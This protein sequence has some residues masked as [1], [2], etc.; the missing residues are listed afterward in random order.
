M[1][2]SLPSA[3]QHTDEI[4][5]TA[6]AGHDVPLSCDMC[7]K[8]CPD[9]WHYSTAESRHNH[10][11]DECWKT[12]P[13]AVAPRVLV[14]FEKVGTTGPLPVVNGRVKIPTATMMDL[15]RMLKTT[16]DALAATEQAPAA[17][18][19]ELPGPDLWR[20]ASGLRGYTKDPGQGPWYAA[21]TVRALLLPVARQASAAPHL[22]QTRPIWVGVDLSEDELADLKR[23]ISD[24]CRSGR[25]MCIQPMPAPTLEAPAAHVGD[26]AAAFKKWFQGEQGKSYQGMWEFARAAWLASRAALLAPAAPAEAQRLAEFLQRMRTRLGSCRDACGDE[27]SIQAWDDYERA[28]AVLL[29][30]AAPAAPSGVVDDM[31]ALVKQLVQAL[32]KAAPNHALPAKALDYLRRQDLLGSPL[33]VAPATPA[34]SHEYVPLPP[35]AITAVLG[36]DDGGDAPAYCLMVAYRSESDARAALALL[37]KGA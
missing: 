34:L 22:D 25:R 12:A 20:D 31:A 11:C 33:R 23:K 26:G 8:E 10:A 29:S 5:P 7:G 16:A 27:A 18:V 15:A 17:P 30:Q 19:R 32:R 21:D 37:S 24:A 14:D 35:K 36:L 4:Q 9:P 6:T 13:A 1:N 3:N 2:T 28:W